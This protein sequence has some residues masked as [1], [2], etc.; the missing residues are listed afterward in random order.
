MVWKSLTWKVGP[1][2]HEKV[3]NKKLSEEGDRKKGKGG[4]R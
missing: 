4:R 3:R 1:G 2:G